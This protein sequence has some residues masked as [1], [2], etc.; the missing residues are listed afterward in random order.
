M[1][2]DFVK[3]NPE[4]TDVFD[5]NTKVRN[6]TLK[7]NDINNKEKAKA[8]DFNLSEDTK[9]KILDLYKVMSPII[10]DK[11]VGEDGDKIYGFKKLFDARNKISEAFE[12]EDFSNLEGL[13]QEYKSCQKEIENIFL[14]IEKNIDIPFEKIPSNVASFR[15]ISLP[16]V[17]KKDLKTNALFNSF[18]CVFCAC[19]NIGVEPS[20]FLKNPQLYIEKIIDDETNKFNLNKM[21]KGNSFEYVIAKSYGKNEIRVEGYDVGRLIEGLNTLES[22]D[23]RYQKNVIYQSISL[24]NIMRNVLSNLQLSYYY[25][26]DDDKFKTLLNLLVCKE[27]EKDFEVVRPY[28][29]TTA[30]EFTNTTAYNPLTNLTNYYP[31]VEEFTLRVDNILKEANS[32]LINQDSNFNVDNFIDLYNDLAKASFIYLSINDFIKSDYLNQ[33]IN[34]PIHS[35]AFNKLKLNDE[36]KSELETKLLNNSFSSKAH[37]EYH[38]LDYEE[39]LDNENRYNKKANKLIKE[40]KK[41]EKKVDK[42]PNNERVKNE[43]KIKETSLVELKKE[44]KARLL[45]LCNNHQIPRQYYDNRMINIF[46]NKHNIKLRIFDEKPKYPGFFKQIANFFTGKYQDAFDYYEV[47]KNTYEE[48]L[49]IYKDKK[50][51]F[52]KDKY[53]YNHNIF[54]IP[55]IDQMDGAFDEKKELTIE[56]IEAIKAQIEEEK[57]IKEQVK[58]DKEKN[59]DNSDLENDIKFFN[60]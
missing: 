2:E 8:Y 23:E 5:C 42:N 32:Q 39:I 33:L 44:E 55:F 12:N 25:K 53:I 22:N 41:L 54:N 16:R 17:F 58:E 43:L 59:L 46:T 40:I 3:R 57:I 56:E 1:A 4:I 10:E 24:G 9:T 49:K 34:D 13:K 47:D 11:L 28:D 37:N 38:E 26:N 21:A 6:F 15:N 36:I 7:T 50:E 14:Y 30:D 31:K 35:E 45:D 19:K 18:Y 48:N 51:E 27:N 52:M 29:S 20:E 60:L